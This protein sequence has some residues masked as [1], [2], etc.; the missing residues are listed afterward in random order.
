MLHQLKL[1]HDTWVYKRWSYKSLQ[2]PLAVKFLAKYTMCAI[3]ASKCWRW[4]VHVQF[5]FIRKA[6]EIW[7]FLQS[8]GAHGIAACHRLLLQTLPFPGCWNRGSDIPIS[9]FQKDNIPV[10]HINIQYSNFEMLIC[11]D[12]LL[13]ILFVSNTP[14]SPLAMG[15]ISTFLKI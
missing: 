12:Y 11:Y 9:R 1:W 7:N 14:T 10:F 4:P 5:I 15:L 2:G 8:V 6:Q 13:S 3:F